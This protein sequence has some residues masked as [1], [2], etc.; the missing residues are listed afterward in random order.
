MHVNHSISFKLALIAVFFIFIACAQEK[1]ST[2]DADNISV[3]PSLEQNDTEEKMTVIDLSEK[4]VAELKIKTKT[5]E[6]K[7]LSYN[8]SI[9]GVALPAP[10]KISLVS[11]PISGRIVKI[12]A[13]EGEKIRKGDLL[14][15]MESL[16][17]AEM[18]ADY[19]TAVAEEEYAAMKLNRLETLVEK[20]ISSEQALEKSQAEL[21]RAEVGVKAAYARLRAVGVKKEQINQWLQGQGSDAILKVY[22]PISGVLTEHLIDLGQAVEGNERLLTI[23]DLSEVL[24]RGYAAPEDGYLLK[25]N[26][27]V[28]ISLKDYPDQ[29]IPARVKTINPA[30]DP[31]NKAISVHAIVPS[32]GSWPRPGQNV[33]M[34]V[35]VTTPSAVISVPLNAVEWEGDKATAFVQVAENQYRR[36]TMKINRIVEQ[37]AIV[38]SGLS[39]GEQVAITNVFTLKALGKYEEF[40]E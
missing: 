14:L 38:Q 35:Q 20:K 37:Y 18:A 17:F 10:D 39:A 3:P 8:I 27:P 22:A 9:P 30:L 25:A 26:D 29:V 28:E 19:L 13:H 7:K 36:Q 21:A 24:I 33:R 23:I 4:Q 34:Q 6:L 31:I 40:A 1:T 16:P 32:Q 11:A 5:V 2:V 15:E 12:Y